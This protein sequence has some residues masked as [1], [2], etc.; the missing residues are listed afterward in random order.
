MKSSA[1]LEATARVE[2]EERVVSIT[3]AAA[4]V[5]VSAETIRRWCIAGHLTGA[6]QYP[7]GTWRIPIDALLRLKP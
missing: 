3:S 6:W 2:F 4:F 7:S 5:G 1:A